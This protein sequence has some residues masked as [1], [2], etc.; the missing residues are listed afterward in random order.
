MSPKQQEKYQDCRLARRLGEL[1]AANQHEVTDRVLWRLQ[2]QQ[3]EYSR[4]EQLRSRLDLCNSRGL[5]AGAAL[6]RDQLRRCC[7]EMI[8]QLSHLQTLLREPQEQA[9]HLDLVAEL[10]QLR[11]EFGGFTWKPKTSTLSVETEP[12]EMQ[13]QYLGPFE[14]QLSVTCLG[15][16]EPRKAYR[17]LAMDSHPPRCLADTLRY[18]AKCRTG[19][20]ASASVH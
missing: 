5:A 17:V 9:T 3:R 2:T 1:M 20:T 13:D 10:Q 8:E 4:L 15:Q 11:K 6:V 19:S 18:T 16:R 14:I 7:P 12:I